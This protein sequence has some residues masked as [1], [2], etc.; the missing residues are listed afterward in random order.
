M[1]G[2]T[3]SAINL[4]ASLARFDDLWDPRIVAT[5][6]D[7]DVRV[8]KV[9]GDF[10]WHKHDDTD[11]FFLVV[12]GALEMGIRDDDGEHVVPLRPGEVF[13]VPKGVVHRPSAPDGASVVVIE[14]AGV[15]TTGDGTT[16]IPAHLKT[17]T[18]RA[19]T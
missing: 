16:D 12:D 5:I 3:W 17:T 15:P 14:P 6:N 2:M 1:T 7:Y 10:V 18:G 4:E 19:L 11:E 13:V 9:R 8:T